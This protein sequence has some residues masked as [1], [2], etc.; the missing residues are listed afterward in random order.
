[1][2]FP[3]FIANFPALDVPFPEEIV[4]TKA[5]RSDAGLVVFFSFSQDLVLPAHSHKAQWGTVLEGEVEL[6]IGGKTRV[7][8]P[9]DSYSI[10]SG[11]EHGGKIKAGSR[12]IDVFEE[13]D[14]YPVK[15]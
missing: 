1:M 8:G 4:Q 2:D 9:G 13:P 14:R 3:D 7:Y 5:I 6:T 11:V 10:P 15:G 12:V